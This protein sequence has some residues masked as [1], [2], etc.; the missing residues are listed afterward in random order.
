MCLGYTHCQ[1]FL[2]AVAVSLTGVG[3]CEDDCG[4]GALVASERSSLGTRWE[5]SYLQNA[6]PL[7]KVTRQYTTDEDEKGDLG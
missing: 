4:Q 7:Y 6:L 5:A 1:L 2:L 3:L